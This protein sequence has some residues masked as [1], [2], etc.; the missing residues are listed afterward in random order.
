MLSIQR[1]V[2]NI[3]ANGESLL[4]GWGYIV[5]SAHLSQIKLLMM[6]VRTNAD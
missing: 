4:L 6:K 2:Y 1:R 3:S 5:L